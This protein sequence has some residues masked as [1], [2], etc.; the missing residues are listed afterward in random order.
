MPTF[1][2]AG[3]TI[4]EDDFEDASTGVANKVPVT[5]SD[6]QLDPSFIDNDAIKTYIDSLETAEV[7]ISAAEIKALHATPKTLVAAPGAGKVILPEFILFSF[8]YNAPQYTAGGTIR[9]RY[10]SGGTA[11]IINGAVA[12]ADMTGTSNFLNYFRAGVTAAY[13]NAVVPIANK[14]LELYNDGSEFATGN[15]TA[16]VFVKYRIVTL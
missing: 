2:E 4:T 8:T 16:K 6:G 7:S 5:N 9:V 13:A 3:S 14:A 11:Y 10:D 15:G 1:P 12:S